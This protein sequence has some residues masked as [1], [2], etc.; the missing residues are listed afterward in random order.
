MFTPA[1]Q[2]RI[3]SFTAPY[4][5]KAVVLKHGARDVASFEA[6]VRRVFKDVKFDG[7]PVNMNFQE[8]SL[9]VARAR[10]AVRPY[11]LALWMF[12]ALAALA[13]LAVIG[14]AIVRSARTLR[15]ARAGLNALGFTDRQLTQY[16]TLRGLVMGV[17]GR[18]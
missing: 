18:R 13:A 10:R 16:A 9:T 4:V 5:G 14:Q 3:H 12:A 1:L 15:E 6:G 11:T 7:E 2:R 8:T 17:V